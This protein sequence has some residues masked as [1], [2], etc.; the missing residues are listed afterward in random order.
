M[1]S[2]IW[3]QDVVPTKEDV[4]SVKTFD[5]LNLDTRLVKNLKVL[6]WVKQGVISQESLAW[7]IKSS[8]GFITSSKVLNVKHGLII[9]AGC[10]KLSTCNKSSGF[11]ESS[12][13]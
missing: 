1:P 2:R 11:H 13:V 12:R 7:F 9:Q 5:A 8:S 4:F 3:V 6:G 10:Y